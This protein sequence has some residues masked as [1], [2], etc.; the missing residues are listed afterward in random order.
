MAQRPSL[1]YHAKHLLRGRRM[2]HAQVWQGQ[3]QTTGAG[4]T[5]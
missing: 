1:S 4:L 5:H 2:N 3:P